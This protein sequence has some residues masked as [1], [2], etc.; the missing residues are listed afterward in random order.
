MADITVEEAVTR[1]CQALLAGN[2]AQ[3]FADM[4]PEAM[5][6]L[7]QAGGGQMP[8][9][10]AMPTLTGY[11]VVSRSQDGDDHLYDVQISGSVNFGVK[12]RWRELNGA[13]KIVDFDGYQLESAEGTEGAG[14]P[15]SPPSAAPQL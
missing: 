9:G 7:A 3:L 11:E 6:K 1:N 12:T 10:G 2:I 15:S 8:M 14:T 13:W 4:T 5:A